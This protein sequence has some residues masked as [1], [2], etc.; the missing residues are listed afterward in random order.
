MI[1]DETQKS[2]MSTAKLA[3]A[4]WR[5]HGS[6]ISS[7]FLKKAVLLVAAQAGVR[8]FWKLNWS[9]HVVSITFHVKVISE[10]I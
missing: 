6:R 3:N 10:D 1:T 7:R 2:I 8:N 9:W 4:H 5:R